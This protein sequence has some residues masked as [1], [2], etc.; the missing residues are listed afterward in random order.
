MGEHTQ[1]RYADTQIQETRYKLKDT[2]YEDTTI[3]SYKFVALTGECQMLRNC[4]QAQLQMAIYKHAQV[5]DMSATPSGT[6]P[7]DLSSLHCIIN[8]ASY[9]AGGGDNV[10]VNAPAGAVA[11]RG[12]AHG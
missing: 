2:K 12:V 5:M 7:P 4:R 6:P 8:V 9:C 11:Q 1:S 3:Q 10:N